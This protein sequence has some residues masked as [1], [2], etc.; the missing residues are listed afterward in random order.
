MDKQ[1]ITS[2]KEYGQSLVETA[3]ITPLLLVML[4]GVFEVGGAIR[5]YIVLLNAN[6]EATRFL[7]RGLYNDD[8]G[9]THFNGSLSNAMHSDTSNTTV[10]IR[11]F[12]VESGS[13]FDTA[14]DV[15]SNTLRVYGSLHP[16]RTVV[17]DL[18]LEALALND[19]V[20][21]V[22]YN[23]EV[24]SACS[25][26]LMVSRC[27]A[28]QAKDFASAPIDWHKEEFVYVEVYHNHDQIIG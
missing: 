23:R 22:Q 17:P 11:R 6:R 5:A 4:L 20:N 26:P 25:D 2:I 24:A 12:E 14:D 8:Q 16:S 1:R 21:I 19:G 28:L 18:A 9:Y 7:A 15:Y 13:P 10:Y 3:I 27:N